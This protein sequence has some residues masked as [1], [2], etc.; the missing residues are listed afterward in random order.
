MDFDRI[1]QELKAVDIVVT[2]ILNEALVTG[3]LTTGEQAIFDT[4]V[5]AHI[6][7]E[8][9][10]L[11]TELDEHT[12]ELEALVSGPQWQAYRQVQIDLRNERRRVAYEESVDNLYMEWQELVAN[13]GQS[14]NPEKVAWLDARAAVKAAYPKP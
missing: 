10:Y 2:G 3:S 14:H 5:A 4:A 9:T 1:I 11:G 8:F 13:N 12:P 7:D 6:T